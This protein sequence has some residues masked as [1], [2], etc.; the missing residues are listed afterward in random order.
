MPSLQKLVVVFLYLL[1]QHSNITVREPA[2]A[3]KNYRIK[4]EFSG[5]IVLINMQ[6][7]RL[8]SLVAEKVKPKSAPSQNSWH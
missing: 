7:W 5:H 8:V 6:M 4:P 2:A 3:G 1:G